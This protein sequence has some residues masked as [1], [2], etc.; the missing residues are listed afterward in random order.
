MRLRSC[1]VL[2]STLLASLS[3]AHAAAP[4]DLAVEPAFEQWRILAEAS[5]ISPVAASPGDIDRVWIAPS[6]RAVRLVVRLPHPRAGAPTVS[7]GPVPPGADATPFFDAAVARARRLEAGRLVIP[8][9]TYTF[10]TL[11]AGGQAQVLIDG[12][13]D[14]TVDGAGATLVFTRNDTG[15]A[16]ARARRVRLQGVTIRYALRMASLGR[17]ERRPDGTVLV[18]DPATRVTAANPVFSVVGYDEAARSWTKGGVRLL[19]PPGS[20]GAPVYAGAQTYRSPRLAGLP[21]GTPVAVFHQWYGGVAIKAGSAR[22]DAEAED[23]SIDHVRISSAP[24]MGILAY[25]VRRGFAV[26]RS[27]I[28]PAPGTDDPVSSEYDGIH[29]EA[30][31]GDLFL[32]GNVIAGSGDDGINL[33]DP[34]FPIAS[35]TADGVVLG[36]WSRFIAPGDP[37]ALFDA[38]DM[39]LGV[40]RVRAVSGLGGIRNAVTL[41][42]PARVAGA[43]LIRDL[44][45]SGSRFVV[46][47]N[48]VRDCNCHG[49]LVQDPDGL[50]E[51]NR[52]EDLDRNA[53][54][55]LTS[56]GLF[57][58]GIGAFDVA[59]RDNDIRD[60][61]PDSAMPVPWA[62]IMAYAVV[63]PLRLSG[64]LANADLLI[65]DNRITGADD[66]C[67][68]IADSE[69]VTIRDNRCVET[70][71]RHPDQDP[72]VV[73]RARSVSVQVD[74][75]R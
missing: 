44:A 15:I 70:S 20:S 4:S 50:V 29:V 74:D 52:F 45:L 10:R 25:G 2:A 36:P 30:S 5:P 66:G 64:H 48:V 63:A 33:N 6:G 32:S 28:A 71:R 54:R 62:A 40:D 14:L 26:T 23:I 18:V 58:E 51:A 59:V 37:V 12:V 57:K 61:G 17:I 65:A 11:S 39:F 42:D 43:A 34:V 22:D 60:T 7:L 75:L 31:G 35:R 19:F 46:E 27:V 16:I 53:I 8:A 13:S 3:R 24:G 21:D 38:D 49:I 56:T 9:G 72:V 47:D 69:R 1:L 41:D 73:T 67:V 55:L 68:T